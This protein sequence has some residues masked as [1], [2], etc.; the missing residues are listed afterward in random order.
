MVVK[1]VVKKRIF[2]VIDGI[3]Q[4]FSERILGHSH[5]IEWGSVNNILVVRIDRVGDLVLTVPVIKNLKENIPHAKIYLLAGEYTKDLVKGAD[6]IEDVIVFENGSG[7]TRELKSYKFDLAIDFS[8]SKMIRSAFLCWV[9]R[10]R[11]RIGFDTGI[12]RFFFTHKV[13]PQEGERYEIDRNFEINEFLGLDSGQRDLNL[14][15]INCEENSVENLL[16]EKG[17][18]KDELIF[19]FHPGAFR[20]V[21][22]RFWPADKFADLADKLSEKYGAKIILT[23]IEE[24]RQIH[25]EVIKASNANIIS[26]A[27][28]VKLNQLCSLMKF[29]SLF[30]STFTGPLH[31]AASMDVPTI[32]LGGP[33]PVKRWKPAGEKHIL[34]QKDLECVPCKDNFICERNNNACME[35][36]TVK[37]VLNAAEKQ[38]KYFIRKSCRK[39]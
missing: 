16:N 19:A 24:D 25:D 28:E 15:G 30:V 29:V 32:I 11:Y 37:D 31:I 12:R 39:S 13:V 33:T 14:D 21:R 35:L 20:N 36:I 17:Y 23:G 2:P 27:G 34:V 38:S 22:N 8:F 3:L 10:A 18:R 4:F 5:S 1:N 9:S 7:F 6:F 26:L